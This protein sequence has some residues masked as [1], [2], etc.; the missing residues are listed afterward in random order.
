MSVWQIVG[1]VA[2]CVF[3]PIFLAVGLLLHCASKVI[4][5][6]ERIFGK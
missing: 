4:D 2:A 5:E 3:G 6:L 1:L